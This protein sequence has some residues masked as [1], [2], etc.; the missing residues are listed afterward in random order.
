[1]IP[2]AISPWSRHQTPQDHQRKE[3]LLLL[4]KTRPATI[5]KNLKDKKDLYYLNKAKVANTIN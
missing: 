5:T 2:V 1:V 3:R 4:A